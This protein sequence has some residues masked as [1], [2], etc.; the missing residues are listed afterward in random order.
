[1]SQRVELPLPVPGSVVEGVTG[2]NVTQQAGLYGSAKAEWLV[3]QPP[4]NVGAYA[5]LVRQCDEPAMWKL[6]AS[7]ARRDQL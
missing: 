1:M 2:C 7:P 6:A 4:T 3:L 5:V